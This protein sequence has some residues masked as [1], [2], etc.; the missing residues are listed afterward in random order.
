MLCGSLSAI[1]PRL[2]PGGLRPDRFGSGSERSVRAALPSAF[3]ATRLRWGERWT[4]VRGAAS[5][6]SPTRRRA[7]EMSSPYARPDC[8]ILGSSG[9]TI[10]DIPSPWLRRGVMP[11]KVYSRRRQALVL[12]ACA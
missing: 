3:S 1:D 11:S 10:C 2:E 9:R 8:F 5:L 12:I 6:A 4:A 7:I